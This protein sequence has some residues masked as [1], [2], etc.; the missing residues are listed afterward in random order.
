M[1]DPTSLPPRRPFAPAFAVLGLA[2]A[3][4]V[5]AVACGG[6]RG[7]SSEAS[8]APAARAVRPAPSAAPS[9]FTGE[10][11]EPPKAPPA[12]GPI[13]AY[14]DARVVAELAAT[15]RWSPPPD[16][17]DPGPLSCAAEMEQ[18]CVYDPCFEETE[19]Q[20]K[21]ACRSTCETCDARCGAACAPCA[22][23]C[24]DEPCRVACAR[25]TAA[26]RQG[27]LETKD[28]CA[29]AGCQAAYEACNRKLLTDWKAGGCDAACGT[30]RACTEG[31][32]GREDDPTACFARCKA[33]VGRRCPG[34]L[35]E[36]CGP[37]GSGPP[38]SIP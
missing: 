34:R 16:D 19:S 9:G 10:I 14:T 18:S 7:A 35:L 23:T 5:G 37:M 2:A 27:C 12:T 17:G 4:A 38:G 32:L 30:Y 6:G 13:V 3:W 20:C 31:C 8:S 33:R 1:I 36:M 28:R 11:V 22:A 29:S 26:C 21:G 25:E 24:K 15:C